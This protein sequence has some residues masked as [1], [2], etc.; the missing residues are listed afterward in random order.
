MSAETFFEGKYRI[1]I[2]RY[3]TIVVGSGAAGY[4]AANRLLQYGQKS[5]ILLTENRLTGTSRNAG[6]DK[7][8]YYKVTQSGS[9]SDSVRAM[10]ESLFGGGSMDGDIA[11]CEAALSARCFYRMVE[12]GVPFPQSRYGEYIGYKTDHDPCS[13][14]SSAGPYTSRYM[15]AALEAEA[16]RLGLEIHDHI[17]C[18]RILKDNNKYCGIICINKEVS[19]EDQFEVYLSA[20][21]VLA[22]GG[23]AGM[24]ADSVY[25]PGQIG[26]AGLAFE[27]GIMGK[28][29]TEWQFGLSSVSPPWNVSGTYMQAV[30]KFISTEFD[31]SGAREFLWDCLDESEIWGK[32]FL[33]GYQWP[34]DVNKIENGSSIIDI[35]VYIETKIKKRRVFLDFRDNPH[36][37]FPNECVVPKECREYLKK[38]GAF[39]GTPFQ[40]LQIMNSPA[41]QYYKE[42]NIDLSKEMLEIALCVQHNNG[43]IA[44]NLWWETNLRGVFSV[45]E[46]CG[47][48]GV[49]RPGGSALNAGQAG[50]LRAAQFISSQYTAPPITQQQ[51]KNIFSNEIKN[52][53]NIAELCRSDSSNLEEM[54]KKAAERMSSCAGIVRDII[55]LERCFSVTKDILDHFCS[56]VN[57]HDLNELPRL[58]RFREVL[59]CQQVYLSSMIDYAKKAGTSRGSALYVKSKREG[60]PACLPNM[61]SYELDNGKMNNQIQETVLNSDG[62]ITNKWRYVRPIPEKNDVF[63]NV[64][65]RYREDGNIF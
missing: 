64:W 54:W 60:S 49:Y 7:Q 52:I 23:P 6:S 46:A 63:E 56:D 32:V 45:G 50:S 10:A 48:H 16:E 35:L 29:L 20:N 40:R 30:P 11:L 44:G 8:T 17:Q 21:L 14:G 12:L 33:K 36:G 59:I 47:T 58:Y 57:Y 9:D 43:G 27:A 2:Y 38:T 55:Q 18:I 4:N 53:V 62:T 25:P 22:T 19:E 28:N 1:K 5:V 26:S 24:Y 3:N 37:H 65:K 13:R 61:F 51:C 42:H 15:T 31:G 41:I 39:S 34:F